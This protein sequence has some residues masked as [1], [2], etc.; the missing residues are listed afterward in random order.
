MPYEKDGSLMDQA[1]DIPMGGGEDEKT[2]KQLF[3]PP[4]LAASGNI[5]VD[6]T[7]SVQ[8]RDGIQTVSTVPIGMLGA[9]VFQ[10]PEGQLGIAGAPNY[11]QA[12]NANSV[13]VIK[14][15]TDPTTSAFVPSNQTGIY[16]STIEEAPA[17][18]TDE[19]LL[20]VQTAVSGNKVITVWC[21]QVDP[22]IEETVHDKLT[23]LTDNKCYYMVKERDTNTVTTL[24]TELVF[25]NQP[26]YTHISLVDAADPHWVVVAAPDLYPEASWQKLSAAAISASTETVTVVKDTPGLGWVDNNQVSITQ[27]VAFDMHADTGS[28]SAYIIAQHAAGAPHGSYLFSIDKTL[29]MV[30]NRSV[31]ATSE[32]PLHSGAVLHV[33]GTGVYT[34]VSNQHGIA[35]AL[36]GDGEVYFWG[37]DENTLAVISAGVKVFP[38]TVRAAP[39]VCETAACTRLTLCLSPQTGDIHVYGNQFWNHS[40]YKNRGASNP[41]TDTDNKRHFVDFMLG[42]KSFTRV[43]WAKI[44]SALSGAPT[45]GAVQSQPSTYLATKG[46]K[47]GAEDYPMVGVGATNGEPLAT[48]SLTDLTKLEEQ[49]GLVQ[50]YNAFKPPLTLEG[51]QRQPSKHPMGLIVCPERV[52]V[53]GEFGDVEQ[54][55]AVARFAVDYMVE[56]ED[57][58]PFSWGLWSGS[59]SIGAGDDPGPSP[60]ENAPAR[61]YSP[62]LQSV[63][64][65]EVYGELLFTYKS[66]LISGVMRKV[67]YNRLARYSVGG[68]YFTDAA[69]NA[70]GGEEVK[71]NLR[72]T[73]LVTKTDSSQTFFSGGY[74]AMFDGVYNGESDPHS[75]PGQPYVTLVSPNFLEFPQSALEDPSAAYSAG[76]NDS[77]AKFWL[78]KADL[79]QRPPPFGS[80]PW[81]FVKYTFTL[82]YAILDENGRMHRSAPSP[83]RI[84]FTPADPAERGAA[85]VLRYLMPPPTAFESEVISGISATDKTLYIE[86]YAKVDNNLDPDHDP[87]VGPG[88]ALDIDSFTLLDRFIPEVKGG[89]G[90]TQYLNLSAGASANLTGS[91]LAPF[92]H[93]AGTFVRSGFPFFGERVLYAPAFFQNEQASPYDKNLYVNDGQF[94]DTLLY[95]TGGVLENDVPPAFIDIEVANSRMW[96][97]PA[98]GTSSIWFSKK[99]LPGTAPQWSSAFTL[100]LPRGADSLTAISSMDEKVVLFSSNDIFLVIGDGPNNLGR[101]GSFTGPRKVSSDVGCTNKRSIANGPFGVM[102]ESEKG[103]Y[104]LGRDLQ[105]TY[106]GAQVEDLVNTNTITSAV[107]VED[108]NQVRF[109]L[110]GGGSYKALVY[111]YFHNVWTVSETGVGSQITTALSA[112]LFN[113]KHTFVSGNNFINRDV[114]GSIFDGSSAAQE[115]IVSSFTTAWLKMAGVQGFKRVKRASFL[116]QHLGGKVSVSAQYNYNESVS[117]T[118]SWTNAEIAALSTDPMQLGIHIPRQKCESIRFIYSDEDVGQ[119]A[120]SGDVVSSISIQFGAKN[121][122]FKMSE[123]SKK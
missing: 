108:R 58:F 54:L 32:E 61:W 117:T 55:R 3:Q 116:G 60:N 42:S 93:A 123:G 9:T 41:A 113:G 24:P 5:E 22:V 59:T 56:C 35:G 102:F 63:R 67:G 115:A 77:T 4:F 71:L 11:T 37:Y 92:E 79:A 39:Q 118:K 68:V 49:S 40:G 64:K 16:A 47:Y 46:F 75:S 83:Q 97:V 25:T 107:L 82:V 85:V 10:N 121:G 99:L 98:N 112:T 62:G 34:A 70:Y 109:T 111:D 88:N 119:P 80:S 65:T 17:V 2:H 96:G 13:G 101:G 14:N 30:A 87:I 86:V 20:H 45:V 6:K 12:P 27:F 122:M 8:K 103:I 51:A 78:T 81:R 89:L 114:T 44:S 18:R 43:I 50:F 29:T 36:P 95:T 66:R 73:Q 21:V 26:R 94:T 90:L 84:V 57:V 106:V 69:Q 38:M 28:S 19:A 76:V 48:A 105:V 110:G 7:G 53:N 15:N 100:P 52:G 74:L 23:S 104:Q 120:A 1:V 91:V 31:S 33:S 72:N